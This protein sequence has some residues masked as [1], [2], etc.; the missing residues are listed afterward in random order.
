MLFRSKFISLPSLHQTLSLRLVAGRSSNSIPDREK[1]KLGGHYSADNLANIDLD[2]FALR[3]YAPATLKGNHL[4][5]ASLEYRFPIANISRGFKQGP[6]F[7][8][9]ERLSGSFFLDIG[10]S[11]SSSDT[12]KN[13]NSKD[14]DIFPDWNDFKSGIGVELKADFN[15]K[16]GFPF[17]LRMGVGKALSAPKGYDVYFTLGTSF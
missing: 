10:N 17:T 13:I 15:E 3:G 5:L 4:L 2:T 11:W 1:F 8:F 7:I 6:L 14:N 16:Y 9:L 12:S